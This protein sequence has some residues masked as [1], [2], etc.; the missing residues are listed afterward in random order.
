M[1]SADRMKSVRIA[2][3]DLPVLQLLRRVGLQQ[4]DLML[5]VVE[6]LLQDLLG[7]LERQIGAADHQ[8]SG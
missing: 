6:Q 1:I 8:R 5:M 2:P 7:R 3:G 4:L